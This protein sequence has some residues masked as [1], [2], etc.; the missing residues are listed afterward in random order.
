[1]RAGERAGLVR[2]GIATAVFAGGALV[3][4]ST[5][6]SAFE[7]GVFRRVNDLPNGFR[8]P[9]E[10]VMQLG[11]LIAVIVVAGL[12]FLTSRWRTALSVFVSGAVADGV[13]HVMRGVVGRGRPVDLLTHVVVR[14]PRITGF[15]YPS[16]H[17]TIA[18]A[19][20]AALAPSLPRPARRVA[21]LAAGLVAIARVYV[22][23]HFPL[24]VVGGLALGTAVGS[25][26]NLVAGRAGYTKGLRVP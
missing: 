25:I 8:V 23:A 14:G 5:R 22:G 17:T 26:V 20:V 16:G 15:G 18:T 21:W 6:P 13:S 1:M 10:T 9:F 24:D 7:I 12:V 2:L 11:T 3:A 4:H 19:L